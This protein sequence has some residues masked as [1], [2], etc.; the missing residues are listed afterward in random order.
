[1]D[2]GSGKKRKALVNYTYDSN[3][4]RL[5]MTTPSGTINGT[6]DA[7]DRLLTYGSASFTYTAN[8]EIEPPKAWVQT[9]LPIS[10]M[11]SGT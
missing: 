10:T 8:G 2:S 1:M 7:Q 9:S 3:S 5:S 4:N 6:Y 11:F